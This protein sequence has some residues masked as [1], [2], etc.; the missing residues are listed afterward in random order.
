MTKELAPGETILVDTGNVVAFEDGISYEIERIKGVKN[1]FSGA[2]DYFS[3]SSLVLERLYY[4]HRISMI[5]QEGL[6]R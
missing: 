4:R 6:H 1:I 3:Q 5:L 2:R